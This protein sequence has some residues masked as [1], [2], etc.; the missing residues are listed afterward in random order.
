MT[1]Q[2]LEKK[3]QETSS[4]NLY[5]ELLSSINIQPVSENINFSNYTSTEKM[6]EAPI[7]ERI[8][9]AINI[10]MSLIE[11]K[12]HSI[13]HID[14]ALIDQLI[15]TLD[16]KISKQLDVIL[17][18]KSFQ[19]V[20]A[21]WRGLKFLV[22]RTDFN[23]NIKIEILDATKEEVADD[24][25]DAPELTQT[26]IYKWTYTQEYDTP[27]GEPYTAL[28]SSYD[29]SSNVKDIFFLRNMAKIASSA[30]MPF[31]GSVNPQFFGKTN[32][33]EVA[34]IKDIKTYF[35]KAEY[36]KWNNFRT[37]EDARYIGL[38]LP[39]FLSRLPY[40][41]ENNPVKGFSYE[42]SVKGNDH[43]KYLWSNASF[44]FASNMV[45]SFADNGWCVQ[46][47]GPQSGGM[48][49]DLPIHV[50]DL[51]T[52][53]EIKIPT[54]ILIP[55]T[56]EFEFSNLGFIPLSFY[57]NKDY[58]CFFSANSVQKPEIFTSDEATANSK[59]NAKMPYIFLSSR[60]AHYLKVLQ[61]ENIGV[62]KDRKKL[63]LELNSWIQN[64]V[65]EMNS[66]SEE[67]QATHPLK[68]AHIEVEDIPD[69]PG[70]YKVKLFVSPHFQVEGLD[71]NLSLV[72]HLPK[73]KD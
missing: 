42:E 18:N 46:I 24:F 22:D 67:L 50:Y 3:E 51:G 7:S 37:D 54:E 19:Q 16:N 59:I 27:G 12:N 39:R 36:I 64:L 57:K 17:H 55:E 26:S 33:E 47:R 68:S 30:H 40:S 61:R 4:N 9:G 44:A 73:K 38:V 62:T 6:S 35:E 11:N 56:R 29:F 71:I 58:A 13:E 60:L 43:E 32:M 53:N 15:A 5:E 10:L 52:G 41:S 34:N 31:I 20:E 14:K 65:T 48:V 2:F 66:P 28:I 23:Q 1:E 70:F 25:A 69:N 8:T 72:S 63:E 45:R 49:E 21:N